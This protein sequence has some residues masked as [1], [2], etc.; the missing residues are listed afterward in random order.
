MACFSYIYR[1]EVLD[2]TKQ[3]HYITIFFFFIWYLHEYTSFFILL[4]TLLCNRFRFLMNDESAV[5]FGCCWFFD[6]NQ[7]WFV[8]SKYKRPCLF[9]FQSDIRESGRGVDISFHVFLFQNSEIS[10]FMRRMWNSSFSS[11]KKK[12]HIYTFTYKHC[13]FRPEFKLMCKSSLLKRKK[14]MN[15]IMMS[16]TFWPI[17]KRNHTFG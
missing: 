11:T 13:N 6:C 9:Q 16:R 5:S 3:W 4:L 14:F 7:L 12:N 17:L 2:R 8:F 10:Y 15:K 1:R